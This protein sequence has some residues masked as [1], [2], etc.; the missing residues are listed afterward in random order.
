MSDRPYDT[1]STS[2]SSSYRP[3][4]DEDLPRYDELSPDV[5]RS[6]TD[7]AREAASG[8]ARAVAGTAK[9]QA[10][11]VV[12]EAKS[13]GRNLLNEARE[14]AREQ[15][16]GQTDRAAGFAK[17]LAGQFRALSEGRTDEA[18]E[19]ATY[20]RQATDRVEQ[21]ADRMGQGGL[22]GV[23][24][25]LAGFARRRP[26]AFLLSAAVAGFVAGR[27]LRGSRDAGGDSDPSTQG[28]YRSGYTTDQVTRPTLGGYSSPSYGGDPS[29]T[30]SPT[31]RDESSLGT[32]PLYP[33]RP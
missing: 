20:A 28:T 6:K 26:G 24:D 23:I 11:R 7:Q 4:G 25:D 32:S 18:G 5:E 21:F 29:P 16:Q 22:D 17:D 13:Q 31:Y 15:A 2:G 3:P 1:P 10:G 33:E 9:D 27:V 14:Q 19:L 8:E 12:D 30:T